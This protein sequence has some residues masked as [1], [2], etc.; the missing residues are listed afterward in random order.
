MIGQELSRQPVVTP[1]GVTNGLQLTATGGNTRDARGNAACSR[2][3]LDLLA[4]LWYA[5]AFGGNFVFERELTRRCVESKHHCFARDCIVVVAC[6]WTSLSSCKTVDPI[7]S[8]QSPAESSDARTSSDEPPNANTESAVG[9]SAVGP[10][11]RSGGQSPAA[12]SSSA[13]T[14]AAPNARGPSTLGAIEQPCAPDG[15]RGCTGIGTLEK[16]VCTAGKWARAGDCDG[17]NRCDS[18]AGVT[19]GSCQPIAPECIGARAGA[20]VCDGQSRRRCDEDLLGSSEESCPVNA[21]CVDDGEI[22]CACDEGYRDEAG[23]CIPPVGCPAGACNPGGRCVTSNSDY[24]CECN[25]G[26]EGTGTKA[27]ISVADACAQI[28]NCPREYPC[29]GQ[30]GNYTCRGQWAEWPMPD[31][32][33]DAKV[34]P[35][36][37]L[38]ADGL[39]IL[40][41]VTKLVWEATPPPIIPT[42]TG[43]VD[44]GGRN[45]CESYSE[46]VRYC[47]GL[48]LA[49]LSDWR[50]PS[51][52]EL[53]SLLDFRT[54]Q[55]DTANGEFRTRLPTMFGPPN[56]DA[57]ASS[58]P[59]RGPEG[60]MWVLFNAR[61]TI[62]NFV[63]LRVRCVRGP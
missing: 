41:E 60:G 30:A 2:R 57:L 61:S 52:I 6:A 40:D 50:V 18:A 33:P 20:L 21:R 44:G 15:A 63:N 27:C 42:C 5:P 1:S 4:A 59:Y 36:Y 7:T 28:L 46:V 11:G 39:T 32:H 49:G 62:G 24:N 9:V 31:T 26:F 43:G 14:M 54:L 38:S 25:E 19:Q 34:A 35:Q 29:I 22:L 17:N 3:S 48:Q 55:S 56:S 12:S 8:E 37:T 53:E 10:T 47:D 16:L 58:S 23:I 13:G 51:K 45:A